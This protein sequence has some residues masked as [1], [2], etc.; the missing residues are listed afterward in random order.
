[1]INIKITLLLGINLKP[2]TSSDNGT[3]KSKS[4]V[5]RKTKQESPSRNKAKTKT[6][7]STKIPKPNKKME[8]KQEEEEEI[9]MDWV[10]KVKSPISY[11][12]IEYELIP[13]KFRYCVDVVC[14]G[15]ITKV[16]NTSNFNNIEIKFTDLHSRWD[17]L[18]QNCDK[19]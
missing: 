17:L 10:L 6:K 14:W 5:K 9:T 8:P 18:F 4:S 2:C 15:P 16:Q 12:R 1:M 19:R 3:K 7:R 13:K 11:I